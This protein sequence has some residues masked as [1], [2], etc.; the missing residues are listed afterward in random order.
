MRLQV[1][2]RQH[3]HERAVWRKHEV[4]QSNALVRRRSRHD[5]ERQLTIE[6]LAMS[7][8]NGLP[9]NFAI[10]DRAK[11]AIE[12][13][14]REWNQKFP[15]PAAVLGIGWGQFIP[16][17]GER[18]ENV[19]VSFYGQSELPHISPAVEP[20]SGLD[21][22]F[23]VTKKDYARFEGKILDYSPELAYFLR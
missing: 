20:A 19:V 10:S 14:R 21:V 1:L 9:I 18:F 8:I 3:H 7:I 22:L 13:L 2:F 15:D 16:N 4:L 23:F 11:E 17:S 6:E 12:E 5:V